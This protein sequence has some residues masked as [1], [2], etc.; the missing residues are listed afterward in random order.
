MAQ[1]Q[2]GEA[3][4]QFLSKSRLNSGLQNAKAEDIW[5]HLMGNAIANYTQ[6]IQII[7]DTLFITTNIAALKN[8]LIYQKE[9]IRVRMNEALGEEIIQKVVIQ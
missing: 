5:E 2:I 1:M 4:K 8:E 7:N 9:L 3:L 6:K